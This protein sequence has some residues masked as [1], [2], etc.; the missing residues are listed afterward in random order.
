MPILLLLLLLIPVLLTRVGVVIACC[1][2]CCGPAD[3]NIRDIAEGQQ[4]ELQR[5]GEGRRKVR[6]VAKE[7]VGRAVSVDGLHNMG[8]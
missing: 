5:R 6:K 4:L 2:R 7:A 3:V 8:G 1:C